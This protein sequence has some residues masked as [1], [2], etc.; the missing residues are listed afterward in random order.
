MSDFERIK[1]L[2][3]PQCPQLTGCELNNLTYD[4]F[5][6]VAWPSMPF[7]GPRAW[8]K[9]SEVLSW[10]GSVAKELGL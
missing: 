3:A 8:P 10:Q 6:A 9:V 5:V 7:L 1:A 2:L 4:I